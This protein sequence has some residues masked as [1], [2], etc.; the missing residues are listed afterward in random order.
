MYLGAL[1]NLGDPAV[2]VLAEFLKNGD[3]HLKGGVISALGAT[4]SA[5]AIPALLVPLKD[6]Y[7]GMLH[8]DAANALSE[9]GDP[10]A[11]GPILELLKGPSFGGSREGIPSVLVKF[12]VP[13]VEPL[14]RLLHDDNNRARLLAAQALGQIKDRRAEQA[15]MD[16]LHEGNAPVIA[17]ASLFFVFRGEPGSEEALIDALN[18]YGDEQMAI[19]FLNCGNPKLEDAARAWSRKKGWDVH[20]QAYGLT[21]G[22]E[23][24]TPSPCEVDIDG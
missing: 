22:H 9:I 21:W 6:P 23:P 7:D 8:S 16:A 4:K 3:F 13:A 24:T 20:Q 1:S 11:I 18:K 17:G 10:G 12:G 14:T 2:D 19:F 15:L 5:R